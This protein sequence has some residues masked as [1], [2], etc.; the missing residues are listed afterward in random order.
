M[1]IDKSHMGYD[2]KNW[3]IIA[4]DFHKLPPANA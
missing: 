2:K 4:Q 3:G 1:F